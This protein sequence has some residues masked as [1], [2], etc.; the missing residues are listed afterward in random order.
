MIFDLAKIFRNIYNDASFSDDGEVQK[1]ICHEHL[2][3]FCDNITKNS[4]AI[5]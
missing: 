3:Y 4:Q 5:A 2:K 1:H